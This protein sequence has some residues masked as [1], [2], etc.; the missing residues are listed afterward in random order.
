MITWGIS[1][2]SHDAAIAIFD[3]DELVF[4]SQTERY[5]RKKND[6]DLCKPMVRRLLHR[7]GQPK[8]VFWYE[9][10][11]KKTLRQLYAGQG[12]RYKQNNIKKY[13]RSY[14]I[15]APISYTDHHHSHAAAAYYTAPWDDCAILCIDSIGEW[16]T[17]TIW[18]GKDGKLE[19]L[20]R[21]TFPNSLGLFYSAMTQRIGL[22]PQEDEYILMGMAA[23]GDPNRF[24]A[25]ILTDMWDDH[26]LKRN[27][28]KGCLDWRPE[29]VQIQDLF[30]IAAAVQRIYENK[31]RHQL[32]KARRLAG[33]L[34]LALAGGCAL[35]CVANTIA[36]GYF[37]DVWIFPNPGDSG[38]CIGSVL[39]HTEKR[40][41][42]R[43][44]YLGHEIEGAYPVDAV[45]QQLLKGN[46]VGVANG[47][48][49][50]G[51]RALGNRSLLAD[52]RSNDIKQK[53]N[54]IKRRQ[55][56]R[57]F[58]PAVLEEHAW[59]YFDLKHNSRFMQYAVHCYK[60]EELPGIVH[61]D[62]TSRVQTVPNDGSGFRKLLEAWYAETGCPILL[63]T[64]LNIKG[65]PIVNDR[66]DA[67]LFQMYY[68][69]PVFCAQI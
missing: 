35:N 52:P 18:R 25:D 16:E 34:N 53:V 56:F 27:L 36:W 33:S 64:S 45:L 48:A 40:L 6:R 47:R 50:F 20:S 10:P 26:K 60:P 24:E 63:N 3:N 57:P 5:S 8:E 23:Y 55:Q 1:G 38:S 46:P 67:R 13:L 11:F 28:H 12:W 7:Y 30:D 22:K 68:S 69:V 62:G 19:K 29:L 61:H 42:W 43:D 37:R 58:A 21:E 41:P 9:N 51:P 31:F 59:K 15:T 17:T 49:E 39:A 44:C 66:N 32:I 54:D 65:Q 2:N 4:A 14:D